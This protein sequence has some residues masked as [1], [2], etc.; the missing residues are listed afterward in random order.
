MTKR[1]GLRNSVG[2]SWVGVTVTYMPT[3]CTGLF[4]VGTLTRA[5]EAVLAR[6]MQVVLTRT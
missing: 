3:P 4:A 5:E 1:N 6:E 2:W